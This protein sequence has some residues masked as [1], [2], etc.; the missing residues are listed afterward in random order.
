MSVKYVHML[1]P[2]QLQD[3]EKETYVN[4]T[5]LG[6]YMRLDSVF[7]QPLRQPPLTTGDDAHLMPVRLQPATESEDHLLG[8]TRTAIMV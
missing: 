7:A 1:F 3:L 5:L 2:S 8:P 4:Q 6:Q